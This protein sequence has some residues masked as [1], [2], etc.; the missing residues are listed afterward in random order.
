[1]CSRN[2]KKKNSQKTADQISGLDDVTAKESLPIDGASVSGSNL[3][4]LSLL[5][6]SV[7]VFFSISFSCLLFISF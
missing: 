5:C 6:F 2:K 3:Q 4:Q 1:M 7:S